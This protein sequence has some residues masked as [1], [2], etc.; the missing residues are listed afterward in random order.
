MK[1]FN[2]YY[3][4]DS[5]LAISAVL[6]LLSRKDIRFLYGA[7]ALV[8]VTVI[9]VLL[10][11]FE[12]TQLTQ[13]VVANNSDNT[14]KFK[15]EHGSEPKEIAPHASVEGVD[16]IKVSGKVFKASSGTHVVIESDGE[17]KTKS[18]SGKFA[19]TIRGGFIE[20]APDAAW[21]PLFDA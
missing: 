20:S 4:F 5:M 3:L 11:G 14:V 17:I 1:K 21:Q 12:K 7:G 8:I 15:P 10:E 16:G 18:L 2:I 6:L 9:L 19:N 13:T